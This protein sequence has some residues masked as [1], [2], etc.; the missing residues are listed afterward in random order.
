MRM[1]AYLFSLPSLRFRQLP[2]A[3]P[4]QD[5]KQRLLK[6]MVALYPAVRLVK[7]ARGMTYALLTRRGQERQLDITR[8]LR[9][10]Q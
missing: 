7:R 3:R 5:S 6:R 8:H 9:F 4:A 1:Q 2:C 10:G